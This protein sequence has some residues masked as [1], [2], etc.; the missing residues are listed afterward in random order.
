[1][2]NNNLISNKLLMS[3]PNPANI[4]INIA[5]YV[6]EDNTEVNMAIIDVYGNTVNFMLSELRDRGEFLY[7]FQTSLLP[8][9]IYFLRYYTNRGDEAI[10]KIIIN[11]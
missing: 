4:N 6:Y 1:M 7:E 3:Y 2:S 10:L 9:G 8:S 5:Y 11:H